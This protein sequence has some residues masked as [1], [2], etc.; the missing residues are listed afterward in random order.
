[1]ALL[2]A[3]SPMGIVWWAEDI[4]GIID[5]SH[6]ILFLAT[7]GTAN[8]SAGCNRF[9]GRYALSRERLTIAG[10]AS[11]AKACAPSLMQQEARYLG[12]LAQIAR[13]R[14]EPTGALV[15]GTAKGA[16]LRFFPALFLSGSGSGSS[17]GSGDGLGGVT[18]SNNRAIFA[19]LPANVNGMVHVCRKWAT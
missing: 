15:L 12:L 4:G 10:V 5:R 19:G 17:S 8:G 2:V 6:V 7:D 1:M 3:A 18:R 16:P 11:T 9:T 14:I 13:W